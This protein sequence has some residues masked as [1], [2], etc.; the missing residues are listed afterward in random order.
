MFK[1]FPMVSGNDRIRYI[2]YKN[3]NCCVSYPDFLDWKT[4]SK[5]FDDMAIVHGVS[6]ILGD[7]I[8]FPERLDVTEVSANTFH[9]VGQSPILGRDFCSR[10]R[11]RAQLR[12]QF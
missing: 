5:S 6:K 3:S 11:L 2:S 9:L 7:A 4:Q 8:G 12:W 1:G 10:M